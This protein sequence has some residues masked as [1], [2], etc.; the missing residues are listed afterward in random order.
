MKIQAN[1]K[2]FEFP[3]GTSNEAIGQALDEYFASQPSQPDADVDGMPV[4]PSVSPS[5]SVQAP[6]QGQDIT[7]QQN[8]T[9]VD[10]GRLGSFLG[11]NANVDTDYLTL[12]EDRNLVAQGVEAVKRDTGEAPVDEVINFPAGTQWESVLQSE[13]FRSETPREKR[14]IADAY[15]NQFYASTMSP[16]EAE[17]ER[18]VFK[19]KSG[20]ASL[21]S[22]GEAQ[23]AKG[24]VSQVGDYFEGKSV[25][26][27]AG[28]VKNIGSK[29]ASDV[30][31][32]GNWITDTS[33]AEKGQDLKRIGSAIGDLASDVGEFGMDVVF[34]L[35]DEEFEREYGMPKS[36]AND[37]MGAL[38]QFR[39]KKMLQK[40]EVEN[41]DKALYGGVEAGAIELA[42]IRE[43]A[44]QSASDI[45][46][47]LTID[48]LTLPLTTVKGAQAV[49]KL[50][51]MSGAAGT[52]ARTGIAAG[53]VGGGEVVKNIADDRDLGENVLSSIILDRA[54]VA[55][56]EAIGS[57]GRQANQAARTVVEGRNTLN[58]ALN[59][60]ERTS[61]I[62]LELDRALTG[63]KVDPTAFDAIRDINPDYV[64]RIKNAADAAKVG[65]STLERSFKRA[66]NVDDFISEVRSSATSKK[67]KHIPASKLSDWFRIRNGDYKE[68]FDLAKLNSE[69]NVKRA[70]ETP[71]VSNYLR[72]S[73]LN[74]MSALGRALTDVSDTA[75]ATVLSKATGGLQELTGFG[76]PGLIRDR[77][78]RKASEKA[79]KKSSDVLSKTYDDLLSDI[80]VATEKGAKGRAH[81]EKLRDDLA[82]VKLDEFE[83]KAD[84]A[85]GVRPADPQVAK[86]FLDREVNILNKIEAIDVSVG[87]EAK[88]QDLRKGAMEDLAQVMGKDKLSD[89]ELIKTA[90][91]LKQV[92]EGGPLST[93][94]ASAANRSNL[95]KAITALAGRSKNKAASMSGTQ[96]MGR[97]VVGSAVISFIG[98]PAAVAKV[99]LA[100]A[101]S[102]AQK[103]QKRGLVKGVQMVSEHVDNI[104]KIK[105]EMKGDKAGM[106]AAI[107]KEEA[108]FNN[109]LDKFG[110]G[111]VAE[112]GKVL[113]EA[114]RRLA[115]LTDMDEE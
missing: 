100:I 31:D 104:N 50:A 38:E 33:L 2:T 24:F 14:R 70:I 67:M 69:V 10:T 41:I 73:E 48:A 96:A 42:D 98:L 52:A 11:L 102:I 45:T 94:Q 23:E 3:D 115:I 71:E 21:T 59:K 13:Q 49:S 39:Y 107:A 99:G 103:G 97:A 68:A 4:V 87:S 12:S 60:V 88:R 92:S 90:K 1:G 66:N 27:V 25:G 101:N 110:D 8:R 15:F 108:S 91:A 5:E 56:G 84:V 76:I 65:P 6:T 95:E 32:F 74:E 57:R 105:A 82:E 93:Q 55:G 17:A 26:D 106:K 111:P 64:T 47:D 36:V 113:T 29:I 89:K 80:Q 37:R 28:D 109:K 85:E 78:Q 54:L 20:L 44:E 34:G 43:E 86:D 16:E 9:Q 58:E 63:R 79:A 51:R 72:A 112:L 19:S 18:E 46:R 61:R 75:G 22:E 77:I 81:Q 30:K 114:S 83:Y 7:Q 53:A 40:K 62:D 35:S